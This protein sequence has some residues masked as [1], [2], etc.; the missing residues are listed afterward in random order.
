[1]SIFKYSRQ[2]LI[3][4]KLRKQSRTF[5]NQTLPLQNKDSNNELDF[6]SQILQDKTFFH[7]PQCIPNLKVLEGQYTDAIYRKGKKNIYD[8][9]N[10]SWCS[11]DKFN[12][13]ED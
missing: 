1:M 11:D 5:I 8:C 12:D 4:S 9:E 6:T 3:F 13:R 10:E 2:I 7:K